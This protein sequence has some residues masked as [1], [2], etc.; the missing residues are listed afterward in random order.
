MAET[1]AAT[2]SVPVAAPPVEE[3]PVVETPAPESAEVTQSKPAVS[4]ARSE[5][6]RRTAAGKF[7]KV[8]FAQIGG[9]E[10]RRFA[11]MT[12]KKRDAYMAKPENGVVRERNEKHLA[13]IESK[14]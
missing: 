6:A 11:A 5:A 2:D 7:T 12:W 14:A 9:K 13:S 8:V 10:C 3:A 4:S 1:K